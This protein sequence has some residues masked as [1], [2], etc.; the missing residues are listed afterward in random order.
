MAPPIKT[1]S[2]NFM[3]SFRLIFQLYHA[4]CFLQMHDIYIPL[5]DL[6]ICM[7]RTHWMQL[8][9]C[10]NQPKSQANKKV[11]ICLTKCLFTPPLDATSRS[12]SWYQSF[13]LNCLCF[14]TIGGRWVCLLLGVLDVECLFS[15]GS[16]IV[17][18]EM[19][20]LIYL[21]NLT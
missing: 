1:T 11:H 10:Q 16:T 12:N 7:C 20:C 5:L 17:I 19:K 6:Q 15:I 3:S 14:I 4:L 2:K 21:M 13:G 8:N 18:R 9:L